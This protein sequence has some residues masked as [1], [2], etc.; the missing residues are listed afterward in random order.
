MAGDDVPWVV[1]AV[2]LPF[3]GMLL[4]LPL[5]RQAHRLAWAVLP[6]GL[7]VSVLLVAQVWQGGETVAYAIGGFAPPLGIALRADGLSA[8][9]VLTTALVVC[10]TGLFA[11]AE[12]RPPSAE[13]EARASVL[14]WPL[15]FALWGA[16]NAAFLGGDLFNLYV[17]LELLTLA[18]VPLVSLEGKPET[19]AAALRYLLFAL[20]GSVL[21][22]V[23]VALLY[24]AYGTLDIALLAGAARS[25][26]AAWAAGALMTAGLLA[27]TA[28]FPL[29][30]W[31]PPAHAGA[32]AAASAV[33]SGLVVKASFYLV[34]RLWFD[35]LPTV[36]HPEAA[37][38]LA[39]L[40][41]AA[42]LFGSVLALR[43]ERLKLAVAYS[44]MAQLGYLFLMFPLT[45]GPTEAQPW[46]AGA[47]NGGILHAISHAFAKS[48]M[49]LAAGLILEA[50]G[51]DRIAGLG[52]IGRALPMTVFAFG[53]AGLSLMGL[54]PSGGFIAKWLL[55][56]TALASGQWWWAV[57]MLAG[58]LLAAGYVFRVLNPALA[59]ADEPV[60]LR[61]P[62]PRRRQAIPLVLA[63]L[64]VLLGLLPLGPYRLLWIGRPTAAEE[65]LG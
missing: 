6:S 8:L 11:L 15:L 51:H 14:F 37:T 43:Q 46:S 23:G 12:F 49:F 39:A 21:Y 1:M 29:H 59:G 45:G 34:V 18:A 9:L 20:L 35:A 64:S 2:A 47:W 32:P 38:L 19:F 17:A 30:L 36:A 53:L 41:T 58:G 65:G 56:T 25:E 60:A 48:A 50:V 10:A 44:T 31:L 22:L 7:A 28:L 5:G 61:R 57:P 40:G 4:A 24:G 16:L 63:L 55:V 26:P 62:V 33:L 42:I 54:P 3:A 27:K 52:G 13:R